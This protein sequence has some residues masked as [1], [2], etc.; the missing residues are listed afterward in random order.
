M[1]IAGIQSMMNWLEAISPALAGVFVATVWQGLLVAILVALALRL[2]PRTSAALRFGVWSAA[3][4]ILAALPFAAW[5]H[6]D[7]TIS[8]VA[9][10]GTGGMWLQLDTRWGILISV[11]WAIAF[12]YRALDLAV[13]GLRLRRLWKSATA[14][15][16]GGRDSLE[17][18]GTNRRSAKIYTTCDLDR[19]SVIGFF[20]PRILIPEWLV[21]KLT[22]DELDQIVLHESEHL[23]RRDDWSNLLQKLI[24]VIFPLNPVLWWMER[25]L[26]FE[27]EMACDEGV[28]EATHAPRSY[29]TCLTRL[30]EHSLNRRTAALSLG[31][32]QRRSEL[33]VR[34]HG[35]LKRRKVL[36]PKGTRALLAVSVLAMILGSVELSRCPQLIAFLPTRPASTAAMPAPSPGAA[37]GLLKSGR[38]S[39]Q[40]ITA[41]VSAPVHPRRLTTSAPVRD[42]EAFPESLPGF[43]IPSAR[44]DWPLQAESVAVASPHVVPT[45]IR[46]ERWIVL[47]SLELTSAKEATATRLLLRVTPGSPFPSVAAVPTG[48]GWLVIQL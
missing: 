5:L 11:L 47:T 21:V 7:S 18:A 13:D 9:V 25:L 35:I 48:A 27:R 38:T 37:L 3:F 44:P 41:R 28:V 19:P 14:L 8:P 43:A 40:A 4:L 33:V 31:S 46:E 17:I 26:C 1:H 23:R 30:A 16:L 10:T 34:V 6:R 20:L 36:G 32:W 39:V 45:A 2:V 42:I 12:L 29:A 15:E 24:L 22:H